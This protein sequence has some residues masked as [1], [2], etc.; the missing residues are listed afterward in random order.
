MTTNLAPLPVVVPL[1]AAAVLLAI[2]VL[3]I[4]RWAPAVAF[5]AAVAETAVAVALLHHTG[6]VVWFGGWA[7]RHGVAIGVAFTID[8]MGAAGA[9]LGGGVVTA[10]GRSRRRSTVDDAGGLFYALLMTAL[11]AIA[12]FCLTGDIFNMFVF[13]ELMAVSAFGLAAYRTRGRGVPAR[14]AQLRDHQQRRARSSSSSA[15]RCSTPG[16]GR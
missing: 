9:V 5:A 13:F 14:R 12:G 16:R 4:R 8:R 11:A 2:D 6:S 10:R 3:S 15:S 7:P 1:A